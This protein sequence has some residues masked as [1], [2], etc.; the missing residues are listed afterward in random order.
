MAR[1]DMKVKNISVGLEKE[2]LIVKN[3]KLRQ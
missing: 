2:V 3:A 1:G